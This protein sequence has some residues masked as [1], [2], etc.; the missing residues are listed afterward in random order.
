MN[1]TMRLLLLTTVLLSACATF[2]A[3]EGTISEAAR[4]APYPRLSEVPV[5]PVVTG[6]EEDVL[7]TR[8]EALQERAERLRQLDIAAL[9]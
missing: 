7:L 8:I 2:P 6:I 1:E 4:D 3:L 5:G 9:Q